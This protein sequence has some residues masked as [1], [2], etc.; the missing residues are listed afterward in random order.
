MEVTRAQSVSSHLRSQ[1]VPRHP[2]DAFR[3]LT[4]E[5]RDALHRSD[6]RVGQAEHVLGIN[7]EVGVVYECRNAAQ[8]LQA[9]IW[10]QGISEETT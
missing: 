4:Q 9:A 10:Q 8:H 1:H 6:A 3:Q 7:R 5:L 2:A